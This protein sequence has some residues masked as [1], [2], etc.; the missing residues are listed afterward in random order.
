M[1]L[2]NVRRIAILGN[3]VPRRCGIATFTA[4]LAKS[5]GLAI[6]DVDIDIYAMNDGR[7]YAYPP[8]VKGT[9]DA[10]DLD[11]YRRLATKLNAGGYDVLCVQHEYGIFG[12]EAGA[13]LLELLRN[14]QMPIIT[15]LHTILVNPNERQRSV[16]EE[17]IQLSEKVV[18]MSHKGEEILRETH[19]MPPDGIEVIP[20]GIRDTNPEL[21]AELRDKYGIGS[22]PMILTFGLLSY[23]KGIQDMIA[24]LPA[25]VDKNP[26][27]VYCLVGATH[28]HIR[29]REGEAH[30]EMLKRSAR[31]LGVEKNIRFINRFVSDEELAGWL[32]ASDIYVTPYLKP[33]Q[34]VSGTLAYA[35]G[36][37]CAVVST[38]YWYAQEVLAEGRGLLVP[39]QDPAAL[40]DAIGG[41]L[42]DDKKRAEFSKAG[43]AY[44]RRMKWDEVGRAYAGVFATTIDQNCGRLRLI[45]SS[46]DVARPAVA[47]QRPSF[48]HLL[49]L[50]DDT[51][52]AQHAA[53]RFSNR[54]EGYC[55][56]D[57]ARALEL[58]ILAMS[59]SPE[60]LERE[61]DTYLAFVLHAFD[62]SAGRFRNFMSYARNW[63]DAGSDDCQGRVLRALSRAIS[64]SDYDLSTVASEYFLKGLPAISAATS[65]R[66]WASGA[67]GCVNYLRSRQDM[68]V[69]GVLKNLAGR[70]QNLYAQVREDDW[71]WFEDRLTYENALLPQGVIEA[72]SYLRD[73]NLVN[74]G[75]ESLSWL[76][77]QQTSEAG[78]FAPI[79]SNEPYVKGKS[80]PFFDQQPLE[81]GATVVACLAASR[82][83]LETRWEREAQRAFHWFLGDNSE[84]LPL[85]DE[86]TGRCSDGLH[87][88]RVNSNSGAESTL[89]YLIAALE[90][91]RVNAVSRRAR[92][93]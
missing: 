60:T 45:A 58:S 88:G 28:P 77:A 85:A 61:R 36:G 42:T 40:A 26:D 9:I 49:A 3:H 15:T 30:R 79:G 13:H 31:K 51:G 48:K 67:I 44:G 90:L 6:G 16:L 21:G 2:S 29:K 70:L 25:I 19:R 11:A 10:E 59:D 65:P 87:R 63:M 71:R 7:E 23:D 37:G 22:R 62:P 12:G 14:V 83:T 82:A 17:I 50:T 46:A 1:N 66:A 38:P 35:L 24:A 80:R 55:T 64:S 86:A 53:H 75:L 41:L 74:I 57:N 89:I 20:H 56:D 84:G 4:D 91:G 73:E 68:N 27:A 54:T 47:A 8:R 81:A 76:M 32:A 43:F 33:E 72:G 52:I 18:V 69:R 34:I 5:I 93:V 92:L 39:F 78:S